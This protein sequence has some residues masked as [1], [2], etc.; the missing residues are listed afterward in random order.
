MLCEIYDGQ[1]Q[2]TV[3]H[4]EDGNPLNRLRVS[5][6]T[7]S[8]ISKLSKSRIVDEL[9]MIT[10]LKLSDIDLLRFS[11]FRQGTNTYN[12][13]E[14]T[15]TSGGALHITTLG[16]KL[17]KR[18]C[19]KYVIT[20]LEENLWKED[21]SKPVTCTKNVRKVVP[22]S[23]G[24][25]P[26]ERNILPALLSNI[27]NPFLE[28]E[29]NN[30][31]DTDDDGEYLPDLMPIQSGLRQLLTSQSFKLLEDITVELKE[32]APNKWQHLTVSDLFPD[33]LHDSK[34]LVAKCTKD[35]IRI[36]SNVLE[37]YTS[38]AF[39]NATFTKAR[40]ANIITRAFE[41]TN[42]VQEVSKPRTVR[43]KKQPDSLKQLCLKLILDRS[44]S[45]LPL[46]VS[47]TNVTNWVKMINWE[48][49]SKI[50]MSVKIPRKIAGLPDS[51]FQLF[52]YPDLVHR[53][54][55]WSLG[56]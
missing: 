47:Y 1:W 26:A 17:M 25:K 44:Y 42:F 43:M 7:W 31:E 56:H 52:C 9:M 3:M 4:N 5:T 37:S 30:G 23:Y 12:N 29:G 33:M 46:Q 41:G 19:D 38:R 13:I 35:E 50:Q 54:N 21:L 11:T 51:Q 34:V 18:P 39:F 53:E 14:V 28:L 36:I 8:R 45:L 2:Y 15:K 22:K 27:V 24:L 40:N 49:Q 32:Y 6:S 55:N 16:G 48:M 20:P 10:S